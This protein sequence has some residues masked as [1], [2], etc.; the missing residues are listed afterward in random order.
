M[1]RR[2]DFFYFDGDVEEKKE[3]DDKWKEYMRLSS[4]DLIPQSLLDDLY[5]LME[6]KD[7]VRI[8]KIENWKDN[9]DIYK[10]NLFPK[11]DSSDVFQGYLVVYFE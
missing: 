8:K 10:R 6:S 4:S 11:Y 3:V 1:S 2:R 7:I 9:R 5:K